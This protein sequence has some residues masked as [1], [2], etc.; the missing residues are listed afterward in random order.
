M[1]EKDQLRKQLDE[2]TGKIRGIVKDFPAVAYRLGFLQNFTH[3]QPP[4]VDISDH[5][6]AKTQDSEDLQGRE[7]D[8][9]VD[10]DAGDVLDH[11][12]AEGRER[13]EGNREEYIE[14]DQPEDILKEVVVNVQ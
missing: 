3:A 9:V 14:E 11:E 8:A 2:L 5:E 10:Q 7:E 4:T 13:G 6:P 12:R 1:Q